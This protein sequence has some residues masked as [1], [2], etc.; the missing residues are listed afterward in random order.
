MKVA[1]LQMVSSPRRDD[2]LATARQL[3]E[4]AAASGVE[5][6]VLPEYFC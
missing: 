4:Q 3:L 2:N 6:A 1:A 5:L